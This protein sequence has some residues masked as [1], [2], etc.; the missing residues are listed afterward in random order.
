MNVS[1]AWYKDELF[2]KTSL[3]K[4]DTENNVDYNYTFTQDSIL[5]NK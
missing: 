1:C 4:Y 5:Q 3:E 2:K